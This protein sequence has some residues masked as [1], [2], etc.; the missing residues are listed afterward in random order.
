MRWVVSF[1]LIGAAILKAVELVLE[2][3]SVLSSPFGRFFPPIQIAAELGI[4]WLVLVGSYWRYTRWLAVVLFAAFAAYSFHLAMSGAASC[5]C[6]GPVR[7]H[8]WWTLGLDAAV[9]FG[10]LVSI[11]LDERMHVP[12]HNGGLRPG[13]VPVG[14]GRAAAIGLGVVLATAVG[15]YAFP[16]AETVDGSFPTTGGPVILEPENWVGQKLPIAQYI[17][18]DLSRGEWIVVLHS[19]DCPKCQ[20]AI[21]R[22]EQFALSVSDTPLRVVLV[23]VPP[24]DGEPVVEGACARA[25][26]SGEHDWFV[27][28]P[29]ELQLQDGVVTDA[30]TE[31]PTLRAAVAHDLPNVDVH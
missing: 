1:L 9:L 12:S 22:Y 15:W 14:S 18:L 16:H 2:P 3:A 13:R 23:E 28:T 6:F 11:G 29:M 5:G 8:P 25:K 17:D 26:L 7:V 21:P 19:R 24:F 10:L 31:L 20:A 27:Q 4:G 30:S